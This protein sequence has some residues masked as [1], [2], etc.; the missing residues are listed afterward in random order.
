M[1]FSSH[2]ID[3]SLVSLKIIFEA[4]QS[5]LF[6]FKFYILSSKILKI[7]EFNLMISHISLTRHFDRVNLTQVWINLWNRVS[8][9]SRSRSEVV[10]CRKYISS[11]NWTNSHHNQRSW[12]VQY[13]S[14]PLF[15][16]YFQD[17]ISSAEIPTWKFTIKLLYESKVDSNICQAVQE[18]R[19]LMDK[20]L[21]AK[22]D[23][24]CI[25]KC[26]PEGFLSQNV[27]LHRC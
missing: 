9:L 21:L 17:G 8:G 22:S 24:Y 13:L 27:G 11:S 19:R 18:A 20:D 6:K 2:E 14:F 4:L 15:Q 12:P 26:G 3:S 16:N 10:R 1:R 23:P 25:I 7:P 5:E